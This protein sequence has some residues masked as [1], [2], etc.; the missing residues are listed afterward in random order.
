MMDGVGAGECDMM[1]YEC[2]CCT[3]M[4]VGMGMW[5]WGYGYGAGGGVGD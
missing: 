4:W 1:V 2:G 5:G 3:R